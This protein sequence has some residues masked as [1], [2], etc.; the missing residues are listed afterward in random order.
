[1]ATTNEIG[2]PCFCPGDATFFGSYAGWPALRGQPSF[3]ALS[4]NPGHPAGVTPAGG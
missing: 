4:A 1:M 2:V 3:F